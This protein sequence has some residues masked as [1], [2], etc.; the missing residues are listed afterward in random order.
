M[1]LRGSSFAVLTAVVVLSGCVASISPVFAKVAA[2]GD[3]GLQQLMV[4]AS[5]RLHV[6]QSG[7]ASSAAGVAAL[8]GL[9]ARVL[10]GV[11]GDGLPFVGDFVRRPASLVLVRVSGITGGACA[12]LAA[13]RRR[14]PGAVHLLWQQR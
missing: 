10:G 3:G 12:H 2:G 11:G 1:A 5:E 6:A 13:A 9:A 14:C 8:R 7:G 4:S